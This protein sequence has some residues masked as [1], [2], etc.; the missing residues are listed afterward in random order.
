MSRHGGNVQVQ[1]QQLLEGR[2]C[3]MSG[4]IKINPEIHE[5]EF[6]GESSVGPLVLTKGVQVCKKIVPC[7]ITLTWDPN[8]NYII[9][10]PFEKKQ[11]AGISGVCLGMSKPVLCCLNNWTMNQQP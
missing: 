8:T 1:V 3:Q 11:V 5:D 9:N 6:F 4:I 2:K 7:T 10:E